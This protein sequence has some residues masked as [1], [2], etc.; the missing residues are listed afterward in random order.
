MKD[1]LA[2]AFDH[3]SHTLMSYND[4]GVYYTDYRPDRQE[5]TLEYLYGG[6]GIG[7]EFGVYS[8]VTLEPNVIGENILR[9]EYIQKGD[10]SVLG[11]QFFPAHC[12]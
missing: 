2:E 3:N 12:L 10:K 11:E 1:V 6:D 7:G 5:L 8:T 4:S 9:H